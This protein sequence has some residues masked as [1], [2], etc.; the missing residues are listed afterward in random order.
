MPERRLPRE[1]ARGD[2]LMGIDFY[3][4]QAAITRVAEVPTSTTL[5]VDQLASGHAL[6]SE[7]R[8]VVG[9]HALPAGGTIERRPAGCYLEP[10]GEVRPSLRKRR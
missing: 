5:E 6:G 8:S 9:L 7:Q 2:I 10:G 3:A 1:Y 4:S